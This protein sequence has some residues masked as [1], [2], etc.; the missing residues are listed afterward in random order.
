MQEEE[1]R[2]LEEVNFITTRLY[3]EFAYSTE[4]EAELMLQEVKSFL[5]EYIDYQNVPWQTSKTSAV[6]HAKV[7]AIQQYLGILPDGRATPL[8]SLELLLYGNPKGKLVANI[9]S[10]RKAATNISTVLAELGNTELMN[11]DVALMQYFILEQFSPFKAYVLTHRLFTFSVSSALP[12][13]PLLWTSC[14]AFVIGSLLFWLYWVLQW[15]LANGSVTLEQWGVNFAFAVIEDVFA[16]QGFRCYALFVLSMISIDP[17]LRYIY[18]VLNR[19]AVSYTQDELENNLGEIKVVQHLSG[20]CRV[21]RM[22]VAKDL[23]TAKILRHIDDVDIEVCRLN[24]DVGMATLAIIIVSIPVYVGAADF[25]LGEIAL[26]SALPAMFSMYLLGNYFL[27]SLSVIAL[28]IPYL[29]LAGFYGWRHFVV[30][31]AIRKIKSMHHE[32]KHGHFFESSDKDWR[33]TKRKQRKISFEEYASSL[34][35]LLWRSLLLMGYYM[36]SPF[37]IMADASKVLRS[38]TSKRV[39]R[40]TRQWQLINIDQNLHGRV[41]DL[42][43]NRGSA[44]GLVERLQLNNRKISLKEGRNF[45]L[46]KMRQLVA[47]LPAEVQGMMQASWASSWDRGESTPY[48]TECLNR[49]VFGLQPTVEAEEAHLN[50]LVYGAEP[51]THAIQSSRDVVRFRAIYTYYKDVDIALNRMLNTYQRL[52]ANGEAKRVRNKYARYLSQITDYGECD[53]LIHISDYITMMSEVWELFQPA[54]VEMDAEEQA[55]VVNT[56]SGWMIFQGYHAEYEELDIEES[57]WW[58]K[59]NGDAQSDNGIS[60]SHFYANFGDF[61]LWFKEIVQNIEQYRNVDRRIIEEKRMSDKLVAIE[62]TR[63]IAKALASRARTL[64][65]TRE[66]AAG[67]EVF[68]VPEKAKSLYELRPLSKAGKRTDM[69]HQSAP[70][71]PHH[72]APQNPAASAA[73]QQPWWDARNSEEDSAVSD[74]EVSLSLSLSDED[75]H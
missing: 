60:D 67:R 4:K 46:H 68:A 38:G 71:S 44:G 5:D 48:V 14:W 49:T 70:S 73:S 41:V 64:K 69:V 15:G 55:E 9:A 1:A 45:Q 43:N 18:R 2:H 19:V 39:A 75:L 57:E 13:S 28:V 36:N 74:A 24:R 3:G 61:C 59:Y 20:A 31:P 6:R 47:T 35:R 21:S 30:I 65:A 25:I 37:M 56:F 10:A 62:R 50:L 52:V 40:E 51:P 26:D 29:I 23:S 7:R 8:S 22:K 58:R 12:I 72:A 33:T 66:A 32:I 63:I 54:G 34:G 16:V 27:L 11:R 53:A 42:K 17:Q